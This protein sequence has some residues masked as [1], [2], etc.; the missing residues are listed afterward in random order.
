MQGKSSACRNRR[1]FELCVDCIT[2]AGGKCSKGAKSV[3][4]FVD[5]DELVLHGWQGEVSSEM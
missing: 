4:C 1:R 5:D 2:L 3:P